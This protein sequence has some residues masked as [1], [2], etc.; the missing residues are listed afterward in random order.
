MVDWLDATSYHHYFAQI[1]GLKYHFVDE[2]PRDGLVLLLLHGFPDLWYGWRKVIPLFVK[3]NY[4]VIVPDLR[5]YGKTDAPTDVKDYSM[6][7]ITKD[8]R[9]LISH[10]KLDYVYVVGHDWYF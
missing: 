3:H 8:I 4:R 6:K 10:L 7:E 5:G 1:N 9:E 2:G